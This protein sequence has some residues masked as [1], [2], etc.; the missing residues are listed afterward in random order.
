MLLIAAVRNQATGGGGSGGPAAFASSTSFCSWSIVK[1]YVG[2]V[3][4]IRSAPAP[5]RGWDGLALPGNA[6]L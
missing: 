4:L 5:G 3:R 1:G 2:A 6:L